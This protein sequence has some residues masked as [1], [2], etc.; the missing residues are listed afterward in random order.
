MEKDRH[1]SE[2]HQAPI[3][4]VLAAGIEDRG[5]LVVAP[6]AGDGLQRLGDV[7]P[8]ADGGT[9][10]AVLPEGIVVAS[11]P[12]APEAHAHV[13]AVELAPHDER[14]GHAG[15]HR[16]VVRPL[17]LLEAERV[18]LAVEG[19]CLQ[20]KVR[21]PRGVLDG[22]EL[23]AVAQRVANGH[24]ADRAHG[25]VEGVAI[26]AAL[27]ERL[28]PLQRQPRQDRVAVQ[29]LVHAKGD[30]YQAA[31]GR[32]VEFAEHL[33][34]ALVGHLLLAARAAQGPRGGLGRGAAGAPSMGVWGGAL[35]LGWSPPA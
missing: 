26:Q 13:A 22:Q 12:P 8:E 30:D 32:G 15:A 7:P 9:T 5:H 35:P 20:V 10:A 19:H 23:V 25:A 34:G 27:D 21:L 14:V 28:L 1:G 11:V 24:A 16:G 33:L 17:A 6:G 4:R 3:S 31:V 29:V 18:G 2:A